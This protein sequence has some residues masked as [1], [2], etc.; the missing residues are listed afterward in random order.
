MDREPEELYPANDFL[1][2]VHSGF[3]NGKS[4]DV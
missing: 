2:G 4:A 3:A 1:S